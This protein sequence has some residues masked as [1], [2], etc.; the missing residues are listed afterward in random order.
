MDNCSA[1]RGQKAADRFRSKWPNAI[2]VHTRSMPVGSTRSRS[3][4]RSFREKFSPP[5]TSVLWA[6][7]KSGCWLSRP[8]TN[9]V[10]LPSGGPS[11]ARSARSADQTRTQ[12]PW[13]WQPNPESKI[14]HRNPEPEHLAT[15]SE[16]SHG[17]F[18]KAPRSASPAC[19]IPAWPWS[20]ASAKLTK[21]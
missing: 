20:S 7:S 15:S 4:C 13:P 21:P 16:G 1:H 10:P 6:N 17:Y 11:P 18:P 5:T 8:T 3:T 14:R 12:I 19:L 9:I 2:L